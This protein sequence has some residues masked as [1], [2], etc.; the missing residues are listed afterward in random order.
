MTPESL[1]I[2]TIRLDLPFR[3]NH[4]NCFL[5]ENDHGW[6]VIDTGL[7]NSTTAQQWENRLEGKTVSDIIIT[8]Y[9]PDHFG[10]AGELQRKTGAKVWMSEIDAKAGHLA[11]E[12]KSIAAIR[13]SYTTS[14][15]PIDL[16]E[17][18]TKNTEEFIP[19]VT[20][21]PIVNQY[22]KE[23]ETLLFGGHVYEVIHTPGHSDGLVCFYNRKKNVLLS[24][25]HVLPHITPN[26]SYWFHGDPNPLKSYLNSLMKIRHLDVDY[27][28]PSHGQPFHGANERIDNI[29]QHHKKRLDKTHDAMKGSMTVYHVCQKLFNKSLTIHELRFAVG[30][31]IAHLEYL[32]SS[33]E[34]K[35][36]V[37]QGIWYYSL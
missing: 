19:R 34:C 11:W 28:I 35:R 7:H 31:T 22:L 25:D 18:M 14:G 1:G 3:L 16:A 17:K 26:I 13:Q 10:Y 2:D 9:H 6:T 23:G 12:P 32:R 5:T 20:P 30:E 37:H 36:E 29:I 21:Y 15:V 4:V 24:T 27:V 8:H 33:N